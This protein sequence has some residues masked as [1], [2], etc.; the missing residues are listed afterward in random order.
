MREKIAEIKDENTK[1]KRHNTKTVLLKV[2]QVG[3]ASL[4]FVSQKRKPSD[5]LGHQCH[6]VNAV[7]MC[8]KVLL[9]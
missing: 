4:Y 5:K 3:P 6:L 9:G 8:L 2:D 7:T 1:T